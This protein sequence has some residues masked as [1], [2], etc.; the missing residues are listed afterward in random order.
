MGINILWGHSLST[1]SFYPQRQNVIMTSSSV[2]LRKEP[3]STAAPSNVGDFAGYA[4]SFCVSATDHLRNSADDRNIALVA[5]PPMLR[6][7]D[8]EP[9]P[10]R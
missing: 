8:M 6:T 3:D 1:R 5:P 7:P 9:V 2:S 4:I 10:G